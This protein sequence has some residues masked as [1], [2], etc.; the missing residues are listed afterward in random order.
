[1]ATLTFFK[2]E[3]VIQVDSPQTVITIQDLLNQIRL[4]EEQPINLDYATIANAYGKQ[5]LG[6]GSY[7]GITLELINDWRIAFEARPGPSTILCT[8]SGGNL[9]AIN[10]YSNNPIKPT[11]FTQIVISQSSSPTIIQADP[12]YATLYLLESLR[13]RNK[14]VGGIWYWNPTSGSDGSDGLTPAKAVATFAKAQTLASA[15]TGDI[16]FALA[17]AGGGTT[18]VTETLNITKNNLK[19][20]G[21][22]YAFQLAPAVAGSPTITIGSDNVE[23][24]GFYLTTAAGGT[25]NGV[26]ITGNNTLIEGCWVKSATA[27]GIDLAGAG[28]TT[29]DTCAVESCAGNGLNLGAGTTLSKIKQCILTGNLDGA[30]LAGSGIADN[31]FENNLIYNNS[32]YGIDIGAGVARTGVRLNHTFSGNTAGPTRDLGAGTFIETQAGGASATD[33]ADAVWDEVIAGHATPGTTARVLKDAKM[34]ATIA[35]LR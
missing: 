13:G 6:G 4:Y 19:I 32:G 26:T 7:I 34:K 30:N 29:I 10:N 12:D 18:T 17:T 27:N 2:T 3:R 11:A 25:D 33:I 14:S 24:S 1:M 20:R 15:G 35:S 31:I 9:V 23:V 28:R 5:P 21:A 8:A 16:I 22:G